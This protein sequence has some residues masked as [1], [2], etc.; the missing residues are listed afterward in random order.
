MQVVYLLLSQ[1]VSMAGC[2]RAHVC[3]CVC[4]CACVCVVYSVEIE[5][6][7]T[8]SITTFQIFKQKGL[9]VFHTNTGFKLFLR[10]SVTGEAATY[11]LSDCVG[12]KKNSYLD[13]L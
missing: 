10:N 7:V 8:S 12:I 5:Q 13:N 9:Q 1:T 6:H 3:V 4:V 2:V 11:R